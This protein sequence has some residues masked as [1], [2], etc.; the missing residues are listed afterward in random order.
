MLASILLAA[1]P[2]LAEFERLAAALKAAPAWQARFSQAYIPEG[3]PA[4]TSEGGR[5][6]LAAPARL[7]FDYDNGGR[8]FAVDGGVAR[9]VDPAGPSCDAVRLDQ[10]TWGRLPLAAVLDPAAAEAAFSI[11]GTGNGL[12]LVPKQPTPDLAQVHLQ[13]D[14]AGMIGTLEVVDQAGTVNRFLFTEWKRS[15]APGEEFF[16]PSLPGGSPCTPGAQ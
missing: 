14:A 4:A 3:F 11:E 10:G 15:P 2:A 1:A 16:R 5:L 8:A 9:F 7:R 12:R 13:L 6:T